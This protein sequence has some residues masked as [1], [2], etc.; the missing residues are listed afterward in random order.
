MSKVNE[1]VYRSAREFLALCERAEK[2][3][4]EITDF[5]YAYNAN[6]AF[7]I[8]LFLKS[9]NAKSQSKVIL[10]V[11]SSSLSNDFT[12]CLIKGHNLSQLFEKLNFKIQEELSVSFTG[13]RCN[14]SCRALKNVLVEL[15]L[16]FIENRYSF[17]K[18]GLYVGHNP[19]LLLWTA[20]FFEE[21]LNPNN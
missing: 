6:L 9:M 4:V 7:S 3:A 17:E 13:H 19:E 16:A 18:A 11:G 2:Q 21:I 5:H 1:H 20:R 14:V 12:N 8:E 10:E 15:D